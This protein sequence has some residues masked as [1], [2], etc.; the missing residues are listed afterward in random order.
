ME[1]ATRRIL[2]V[3]TTAQPTAAWTLQQLREA[4]PT[5]HAYDFLIHDRDSVDSRRLDQCVRHWGL[6]GLRTPVRSPQANAICER[7]LDT[8]R[9]EC[10]DFM[11]PLT[12]H[13]L[14]CVLHEC[15]QHYNT[16]RPHMAFGLASAQV[17]GGTLLTRDQ[18]IIDAALVPMLA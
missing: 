13:H 8:L 15:G 5:D 1:H 7:L 3:H 10:L 11:I 4:I 6:R 12:E 17:L 16:G 2:H 14:W 18:R 9:R